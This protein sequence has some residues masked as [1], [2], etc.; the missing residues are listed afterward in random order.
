MKR[1]YKWLLSIGIAF[2]VFC[3]LIV[4]T[5]GQTQWTMIRLKKEALESDKYK[6]INT[7]NHLAI[8]GMD[9]D[10]A[11]QIQSLLPEKVVSDVMAKGFGVAVSYEGEPLMV[12][13]VVGTGSNMAEILEFQMIKG[14]YLSPRDIDGY[15]KVCVIKSNVYD[16]VR[17]RNATHIDLNGE[18]YEIIGVISGDEAI[19]EE[20]IFV[21]VTTLYKYIEKID[22]RSGLI[23]KI[24]LDRKGLSEEYI[25]SELGEKAGIKGMGIDRLKLL[26]YQYEEASLLNG[27]NAVKEFLMIFLL[28]LMVLAVAAFNIIHIATASIIDRER[29]I[30][31][32][33][34]IGAKPGHIIRQIVCEILHCALNGGMGGIAAASIVNTLTNL[35]LGQFSLSFNAVSIAA[36]ILLAAMTGL[37]TSM[38]PAA[39]A[40]MIDPAAALREE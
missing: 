32:R 5:A 1:F 12:G 4:F 27:N 9:L 17:T 13:Q 29:E 34:A 38:L 22:E 6:I 25:W 28:S 19:G 39:R 16:L 3:S 23:Y 10:F 11:K 14:R 8:Y 2:G 35:G 40:A 18:P 15:E 31:L 26:P 37:I 20:D 24:V 36:G 21:P 33:T 7:D 30:G